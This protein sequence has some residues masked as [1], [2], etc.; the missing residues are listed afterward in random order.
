MISL[1]FLIPVVLIIVS[2]Q[3]SRKFDYLGKDLDDAVDKL[4]QILEGK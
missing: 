1:I 2:H 3:V 4:N